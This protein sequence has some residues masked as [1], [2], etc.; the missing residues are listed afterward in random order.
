QQADTF[1]V[2]TF[3]LRP[4]KDVIRA[5]APTHS[6]RGNLFD[7]RLW[8][9][10]NKHLIALSADAM[11]VRS[12]RDVPPLAERTVGDEGETAHHFTTP[13]DNLAIA[14]QE[15][16]TYRGRR[17][18]RQAWGRR[19]LCCLS[20]TV[21]ALISNHPRSDDGTGSTHKGDDDG[22]TRSG[23]TDDSSHSDDS[24][25]DN[26]TTLRLEP[27]CRLRLCQ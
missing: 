24:K 27:R 7:S 12:D 18:S 8:I 4:R 14:A 3:F 1:Y 22:S 20:A 25:G 23:G 13:F 10:P 16:G 21:Q 19:R 26:R 9:K 15:S 5:L 11:L 2:L 6:C 17:Q